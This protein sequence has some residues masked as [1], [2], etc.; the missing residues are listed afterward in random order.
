MSIYTLYKSREIKK[1]IYREERDKMGNFLLTTVQKKVFPEG[2]STDVMKRI[3]EM[4]TFYPVKTNNADLF[5]KTKLGVYN[6]GTQLLTSNGVKDFDTIKDICKEAGV[7]VKVDS[8]ETKYVAD[9]EQTGSV[10][11][12]TLTGANGIKM[13]INDINAKQFIKRERGAFDDM[14][15]GLISEVS[16]GRI[17]LPKKNDQVAA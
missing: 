12:Y 6:A 1:N 4:D 8:V 11:V 7:Q 14:L 16:T 10:N 17:Q 5:K 15:E 9:A 2:V 13:E 3:S